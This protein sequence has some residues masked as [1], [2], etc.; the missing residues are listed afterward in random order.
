MWLIFVLAPVFALISSMLIAW[1]VM[2]LVGALHHQPGFEAVPAIGFLPTLL[3][4]AIIRLV[5]PASTSTSSS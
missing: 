3:I 2:L 4:V 5:L 1:P